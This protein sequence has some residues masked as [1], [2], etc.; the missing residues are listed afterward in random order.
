MSGLRFGSILW[1]SPAE[2]QSNSLLRFRLSNIA[3][4]LIHTTRSFQRKPQK[5]I[6]WTSW[7]GKNRM[8]QL[9]WQQISNLRT[10]NGGDS[11]Y[12]TIFNLAELKLIGR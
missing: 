2:P 4:G 7:N 5:K 11:T 6:V 8:D 12:T 10:G 9:Q 1:F 3:L